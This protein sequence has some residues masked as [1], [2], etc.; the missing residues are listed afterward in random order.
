LFFIKKE[1]ET[2]LMASTNPS[3]FTKDSLRLNAD[4][5]IARI[6]AKIREA[7]LHDLHRRGVVV[8]ISGGI[9][10]SVVLALCVKALGSERVVGLI[11]P[12]LESSPISAML[13]EELAHHFGIQT[14]TE[15]ISPVLSAFGCYERRNEAIRRIFPQFEQGWGVKIVLPNDL[16]TQGTLNV[17]QLVVTTPQGEEFRQRLAPAEYLQIVASSNFKQRVRTTYLYFHAEL[18]NYAVL[19][20]PNKN[21]HALGFFVKGGDGLYD[22]API[23]HLFK[24]QV[25]QLAESLGVPQSI[26]S[27]P[28]IT[29]TYPGGGTQEE[30][31][32]R[33]PFEILDTIWFGHEQQVPVE[34]IATAVNLTPEQVLRVIKD[35]NTKQMTTNILREPPKGL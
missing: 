25:F 1:Q 33:L 16:L 18:R 2:G 5:E 8:G 28:P 14:V 32:F 13:A 19:G 10:S 20:T 30:F 31:F 21:E 22:F 27:R 11:M 15:D 9:D 23:R 17:F 3:D 26:C 6:V 34:K 12:E 4:Q 35:I 29:D 24:T 7:V